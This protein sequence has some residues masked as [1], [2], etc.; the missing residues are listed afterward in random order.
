MTGDSDGS[1]APS[2]LQL[3]CAALLGLFA[4]YG[5]VMFGYQVM[6]GM[7]PL[8]PISPCDAASA[9]GAVPATPGAPPNLGPRPQEAPPLQTL[10]VVLQEGRAS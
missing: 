10:T 6:G 1:D 3:L 2:V 8:V 9:S 7:L 4:G 5:A